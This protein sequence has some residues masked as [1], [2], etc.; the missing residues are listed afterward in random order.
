MPATMR[1]RRNGLFAALVFLL[2]AMQQESVLH[3]FEHLRGQLA[4]SHQTALH[5]VV[6]PCDEC[7]LLAGVAH[8]LVGVAAVVLAVDHVSPPTRPSV[9]TR[10]ADAPSF[11]RSRAPPL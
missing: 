2:L 9:T 1:W 5:Q 11:Y 8:S 4:D 6:A 7:S 10:P 3:S